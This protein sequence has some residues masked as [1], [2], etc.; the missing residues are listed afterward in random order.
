MYGNRLYHEIGSISDVGIGPKKDRP[1]GDCLQELAVIGD[2]RPHVLR[3]AQ[4]QVVQAQRR[5]Q[6]I[7]IR[8]GIVQKTGEYSGGPEELARGPDA[9]TVRIEF[10]PVQRRDHG[11]EYARKQNRDL[12]DGSEVEFV[13]PQRFLSGK[14]M[15]GA[16]GGNHDEFA[17]RRAGEDRHQYDEQ[18]EEILRSLQLDSGGFWLALSFFNP[19]AIGNRVEDKEHAEHQNQGE[20]PDMPDPDERPVEGNAVEVSQK[21]RRVANRGQRAPNVADDKDKE[22]NVEFA[23]A[24][25]V[26]PDEGTD[27]EHGSSRCA[28]KV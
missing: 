15:R 18:K 2:K 21:E 20:Q 27:E 25:L 9:Q 5:A 12:P 10:Q 6:K 17:H 14:T 3:I 16:R 4:D 23:D 8:G 22:H 11:C 13:R 1:D 28:K 19:S 24:E 26:D 7:E